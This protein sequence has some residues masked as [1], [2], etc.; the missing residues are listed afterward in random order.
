MCWKASATGTAS[1]D[2]SLLSVWE[3]SEAL[4]SGMGDGSA[5]AAPLPCTYSTD[6]QQNWPLK[7]NAEEVIPMHHQRKA[8]HH[9]RRHRPLLLWGLV[10]C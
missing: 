4:H 6:A 8:R 7:E 10:A 5:L 2:D 9:D 1:L 3:L